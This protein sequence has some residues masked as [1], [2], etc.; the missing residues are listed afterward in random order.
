MTDQLTERAV[1]TMTD[2]SNETFGVPRDHCA[3]LLEDVVSSTGQ[4]MELLDGWETSDALGSTNSS[5][6]SP[7][8]QQ[9]EHLIMCL[10]DAR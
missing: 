10:A 1:C 8:A 9:K 3:A 4:I 6:F 7:R 2:T 5:T